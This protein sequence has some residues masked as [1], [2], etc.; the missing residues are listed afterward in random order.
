MIFFFSIDV[1][2][3]TIYSY[4]FFACFHQDFNKAALTFAINL[5]YQFELRIQSSDCNG[6]LHQK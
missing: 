4:S 3:R 5:F 6:I 1:S 2:V